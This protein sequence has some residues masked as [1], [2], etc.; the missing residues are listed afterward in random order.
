MNEK[1]K[2]KTQDSV[3]VIVD[4]SYLIHAYVID[5]DRCIIQ[6]YKNYV[7]ILWIEQ[8]TGRSRRGRLH[9]SYFLRTFIKLD[10][11]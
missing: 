3:L 5:E 2:Y 6:A 10:H 7:V 1:T 11:D 9:V 8:N 4:T